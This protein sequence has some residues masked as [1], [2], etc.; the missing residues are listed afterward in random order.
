MNPMNVPSRS[1]EKDGTRKLARAGAALAAAA[2]LSACATFS[3]DG[4]MD[5]VAD[6]ASRELNKDAIAIRT[7]EQASAAH[8]AVAR[9]LSRTLTADAAVQI[10]LLNNRG[11]Q[12]AY[13]EL[14]L[15][16]AR[17]V[18]GSLPPNPTFSVSRIA[19]SAEIEIE[20]RIVADLLAI[21]TLQA[22]SEIA[23]VRFRQAQLRAA[24]ETLRVAAEVRRAYYRAVAARE[25]VGLLTQAK[26]TADTTAQLAAKLGE[27]GSLNKLDQ[28][29]EQVFYAETTAELASVRQ[30]A[31]S[32]RER[33]ARLLGLW[34]RHLEFKL[35]D[36]LPA[37][38]GRPQTLPAIELE[39][40][41]RRVDL[42]I[43][44]IEL[45]ALA[46]SYGLTQA[47]R[48]INLLEVGAV[49]KLTKD[50][51]SGERIRDRGFELEVQ[52]PLFD[53]GEVRVRQAEATY[54][55]AV[56]RLAERAK[57]VRSEARDA[58]RVYRSAYDIAA[59]YRRE[60]LP[61]RKIISDETLLRYN[62][63]LIDVF[64]LLGEARQRITATTAAIEARR[65]FWLAKAD[66]QTAVVGGGVAV[67]SRTESRPLA[68]APGG[69]AGH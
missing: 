2:A 16:E 31:T 10:A 51:A 53:F 1:L 36:A 6:I 49:D 22:R 60:V 17:R 28:T 34:G 42:Q 52:I 65:D 12:A 8:A 29:R 46:R 5:I 69:A 39:A 61:L 56:N 59:H 47:T 37:L 21:A 18:E 50:K 55:Q 26:S 23:A 7:P 32:T 48:F 15:A 62:A 13:D 63:M 64:A 66:L 67:E 58:Y 33:L 43:A 40:V 41:R 68:G 35:P 19:G 30:D 11:L 20:R 9:L 44:R 3:P 45:D 24:E 57:K 27:T 14:A 54:M 25:V 4:G 38:P